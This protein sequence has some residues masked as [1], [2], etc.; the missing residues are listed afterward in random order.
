MLNRRRKAKTAK[1]APV[2]FPKS[3]P[4]LETREH[5]I[6]PPQF[7][8]PK[9]GRRWLK[10]ALR[11]V[12]VLV[13]VL[14]GALFYVY[15]QAD[16]ILDE[17]SAGYKE[18]IVNNLRPELNVEPEKPLPDL[19]DATTFL[20]VGSDIRPGADETYGRSDTML[21][22]RIY[23]DQKAASLLSL[24]RDLYVPI[25]GYGYDKINAAFS[26]GGPK[27]LIETVREYL[28]VPIDHYFQIDFEGFGHLVD[29]FHGVYLPIDQRY[30]HTNAGLPDYEH[31]SEIDLKPGYQKLNAYDALAF[32]RSRHFDTDFHRAA[33]QQLFLREVGRQL[34]AETGGSIFKLRDLTKT[35]AKA[36]ISDLDNVSEALSLANTLRQIPASRLYR[37]TMDATSTYIGYTYYLQASEEQKQEALDRWT[38]PEEAFKQQSRKPARSKSEIAR[39]K[40]AYELAR[41]GAS[42]HPGSLLARHILGPDRVKAMRRRGAALPPPRTLA[43]LNVIRL[44]LASWRPLYEQTKEN[45]QRVRRQIDADRVR[46]FDKNGHEIK[47]KQPGKHKQEGSGE[48]AGEKIKDPAKLLVDDGGDGAETLGDKPKHLN[49]CRPRMVPSGYYFP[50]QSEARHRYNINGHDALALYATRESGDSILWMWTSWMN[51]PILSSPDDAIEI[52][53]KRYDLYWESG[54]LRMIAWADQGT[55]IW[56]TNTLLNEVTPREMIA[57][58]QTCT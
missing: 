43:M 44:K 18:P 53:G 52:D 49:I 8:S 39:L 33:R 55:R 26:Y 47:P 31:F 28:G 29:T 40:R 38:H 51:P 37:V 32:V 56:I 3:L 19:K 45:Y 57:L 17:F 16:S 46:E 15:Q 34:R 14:A 12:A 23:P 25:P 1:P 50:H 54:A 5:Q 6:P 9:S 41:F 35:I 36:S 13:W 27:L 48:K 22:L 11:V 20:L 30:Y 2:V 7:E 10:W 21:V 4:G 58:A 24:P 42:W